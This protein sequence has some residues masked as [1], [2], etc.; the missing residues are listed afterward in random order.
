[1]IIGII[2]GIIITSIILCLIFIPKVKHIEQVNE[3][4]QQQNLNAQITLDALQEE[5]NSLNIKKEKA[6]ND[7][8]LLVD[9][10]V[11]QQMIAEERAESY[12]NHYM[13]LAQDRF[14]NDLEAA[15]RQYNKAENEFQKHYEEMMS[16]SAEELTNMIN[17][18]RSE[19]DDLDKDLDNIY[20][21]L[22]SKKEE[23][24]NINESLKILQAEKEQKN[25]YRIQLQEANISEIA[26]LKEV[27]P[28]LRDADPV[29][30]IIWKSY[31]E[32]PFNDMVGRVIGTG[33]HCGI[34]KITNMENGMAYVG[35][36]V[37]II[38]RWRTHVKS[39][40]G[41]GG[42]KNKLYLAMLSFG[43]ENFTF[44]ILE[45]C[46]RSVLNER[47]K[48]WISNFNTNSYG[49]NMTIGG[50]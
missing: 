6:L 11:K 37:D 25:F 28:Y 32:K 22:E 41:I 29:Y 39:G 36:S 38:E 35:Q 12:Y 34:Y 46:D 4:V 33:K 16:S 47:E 8:K 3:L 50:S 43:V 7:Y 44:E 10:G 1:M 27:V 18:K 13:R 30:K 2:I 45:E 24:N 40:L 14:S 26:H 15:E 42:S 9:E 23:I 5:L 20:S 31:Y 49:Y 17:I 48:L 21:L 19:I